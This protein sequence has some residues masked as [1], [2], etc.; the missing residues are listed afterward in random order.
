MQYSS[1]SKNKLSAKQINMKTEV[2]I[3]V[4]YSCTYRKNSTFHNPMGLILIFPLTCYIMM[5]AKMAKYENSKLEHVIPQS[6]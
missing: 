5:S 3:Y 1:H 4:L 6:R 2:I